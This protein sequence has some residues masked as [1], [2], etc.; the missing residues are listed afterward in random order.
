MPENLA[1][2]LV[3]A[4]IGTVEKLGAMTPEELEEVPGIGPKMVERIQIAVNN[5]YGQFEQGSDSPEGAPEEPAAAAET[6]AGLPA[7]SEAPA[8]ASQN[9]AGEPE[10]LETTGE[11]A[12][13]VAV[14]QGAD[15]GS[16]R[17]KDSE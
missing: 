10:P 2:K 9:G 5:Y 3:E 12:P 6:D 1:D 13:E 11:I 14:N 17:M 4:G 15:D 16:D 7:Q 8:V